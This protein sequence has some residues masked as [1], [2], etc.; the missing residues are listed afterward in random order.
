M[1]TKISSVHFDA[2]K[3]LLELIE[4]KIQK[5][6]H[7]HEEIIGAEVKLK[8]D[9]NHEQINKIIEIRLEIAGNDLF[10]KRTC[11]SFE[12]AID[13]TLDALKNQLLK[14]KGKLNG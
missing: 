13:E 5:L 2:D 7:L 1:N 12:E 3:K 9:N 10:A 11:K 6:T 14:Y 8:L 4:K